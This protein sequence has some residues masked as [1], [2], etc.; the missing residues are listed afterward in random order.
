MQPWYPQLA[1]PFA[2]LLHDLR[3][4]CVAILGH[5]R[6]DPDCIGSQIGLCRTLRHLGIEALCL[7][8]HPVPRILQAFT[9]DT[10]FAEAQSFDPTGWTAVAVDCADNIRFGDAINTLFPRIFANI[11]HHISNTA[12]AQH[13]LIDP[14]SAATGEMLTGLLLDNQLP[15]D[16]VSAQALY[17]AIVTDTG[18]FRYPSTSPRVFSL[19]AE[20]LRLGAS[21]ATTSGQLYENEPR[22]KLRLL[23][24]FLNSLRYELGGRLCIGSL[25]LEAFTESGATKEDAEG[26]VDYARDIEGVQIGLLLEEYEPGKTKGS[27]RAK[28]PSL[29]MDQ[30]AAQLG[31]GGHAAAAGF[32]QPLPLPDLLNLTLQTTEKHLR[33]CLGNT[34]NT[35]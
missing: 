22:A 29:R 11:D 18:M 5:L 2:Q 23:S 14:D 8:W 27:L 21:P 3:G 9:A 30:L 25:P 35:P 4:H 28:D 12:Y 26:F 34:P 33:N 19:C 7:N 16:P 32:N 15:I 1:K 17:T 10:P 20:L 13:N 31:G 6:P 24:S